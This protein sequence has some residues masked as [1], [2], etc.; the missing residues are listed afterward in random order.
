MEEIIES[1]SLNRLQI[2]IEKQGYKIELHESNGGPNKGGCYLIEIMM[3]EELASS[4][5]HCFAYYNGEP[6]SV[7]NSVITAINLETF[8]DTK[9]IITAEDINE[10]NRRIIRGRLYIQHDGFLAHSLY[11][12][13]K[14][15]VTEMHLTYELRSWLE[16]VS[17]YTQF[18]DRVR[19]GTAL[20]DIELDRIFRNKEGD[21]N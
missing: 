18:V 5:V 9:N 17:D 2:I 13:L 19:R 21:E 16:C 11:T 8:F 7:D 15:G 14:G 1:I 10:I 20:L 6:R 12:S 4:G 3:A